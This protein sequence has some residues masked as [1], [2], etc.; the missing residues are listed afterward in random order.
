MRN[1]F[2]VA[3]DITDKKRLRTV[4]SKMLGFGEPIQYSVFICDLSPSEAVILKTELTSLV[5]MNEDSVVMADM[6]PVGGSEESR[7]EYIG[8]SPNITEH[9]PVVV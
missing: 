1:R 8:K 5:K 9:K 6:G 3:Y 2:I 7:F 4:H